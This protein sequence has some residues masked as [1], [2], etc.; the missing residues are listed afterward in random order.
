M[1]YLAATER[2]A[3]CDLALE[4]GPDA[5]T[6]CGGWDVG[7]LVAH[8]VLRDGSLSAVGIVV[9]ALASLTDRGMTRLQEGHDF[10]SLVKR[11]RKGPPLHS[12][13]RVKSVDRLLNAMEYYVH[14]EDIR[15]A[16]P[17]WEPRGLSPRI[18]DALWRGLRTSGRGLLR[19]AKVGVVAQR[20]DGG[21]TATLKGGSPVVT[22]TGTPEE[23]VLFLYGR[24]EHSRAELQGDESAI[25]SL[26]DTFMGV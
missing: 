9:P 21:D 18:Q 23:L 24:K 12:P 14:H 6:L 1:T 8:L 25:T 3:L 19:N 7:D 13:F 17:G 4:T 10:E 26:L 15:R 5:P 22:V 16:Q 20:A 11:L 2:T